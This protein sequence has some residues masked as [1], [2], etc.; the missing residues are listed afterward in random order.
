MDSLWSAL[1]GLDQQLDAGVGQTAPQP[2]GEAVLVIGADQSFYDALRAE[3]VPHEEVLSLVSTCKPYRNL[4]RIRRGD[5]FRV[6]RAPGGGLERLSFD[7]DEESYLSFLRSGDGWAIEERTHPVQRRLVG[8]SGIIRVSLYESLKQAAAPLALAT[9]INDILGWEI[10]FNRDLRPGDTFRVV[11]EEVRR[12]GAFVR[13]GPVL[14]VECVNRGRAHRAFRFETRD[15]KPGYYDAQGRNLEKQMLK[16]PLEYAR[17][18]SP[19]SSRRFHPIL[20]RYM[21]HEGIDYAAPVGTP[22]RASGSGTVVSAGVKGGNGRYVH[23]RHD[24]R[25][26]ESYY[27]H[28]S[29]FAGGIRPGARVQ[30][31]QVIGYVGATGYA[32]GPHLDYRVKKDGRFVD[33]RGLHLPPAEPVPA[34]ALESFRTVVGIYAQALEGLDSRV[35][36]RQ[37]ALAA[38]VQPPLWE[39]PPFA[40]MLAGGDARPAAP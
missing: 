26:Y 33:P 8:V 3:G 39:P 37:T 34:G 36:P 17:I 15:G 29:R 20:K 6:V 31:G 4:Q 30:Q 1:D 25:A 11:Y 18:S 12:D 28:L 19:F 35:Q 22:V 7:L 16:A 5:R 13:T 38:I 23:I 24:N 9:K 10:D 14:A 40:S 32:T 27:L 21:P 2:E